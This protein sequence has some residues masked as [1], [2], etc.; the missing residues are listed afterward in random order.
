MNRLFRVAVAR[1]DEFEEA[2]EAGE[3]WRSIED[4]TRELHESVPEEDRHKFFVRRPLM[5]G[6]LWDP[7]DPADRR[8]VVEEMLDGD[9]ARQSL[10]SVLEVLHTHPTH[11]DFSDRYSWVKEDFERSFYSKRSRIK[12]TLRATV[13]DLPT[14]SASEP[15]GYGEVLFRDVLAFFD[16]RD[17]HILIALRHGKTVSEIA[18]EAG[19]KGHAAVA[20]RVQAIK[21]KV[22]KLLER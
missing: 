2:D 18:Q 12:V 10:E 22:R 21:A 5:G 15:D 9:G 4:L 6:W 11:E 16:R 14:W 8:A 20:R 3:Q 19:H 17:R 1:S 13:D 7:E